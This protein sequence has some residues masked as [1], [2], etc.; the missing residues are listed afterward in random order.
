MSQLRQAAEDYLTMR[1][2]LG[3]KLQTQGQ[4]LIG[5]VRYLE[6]AGA[7]AVT[8]ELALA[9]ATQSPHADAVWGA[10]SCPRCV[11]SP[12]I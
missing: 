8:T 4:L 10:R 6:Q 1:R 9:W 2:A 7:A 5:F 11:A 3:F 12:A